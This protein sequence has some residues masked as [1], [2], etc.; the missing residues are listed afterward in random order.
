MARA[1]SV[2][3][4]FSDVFRYRNAVRRFLADPLPTTLEG[5][6]HKDRRAHRDHSEEGTLAAL[7]YHHLYIL[8]ARLG[9]SRCRLRLARAGRPDRLILTGRWGD[10]DVSL[11]Y[12]AE[13]VTPRHFLGTLDLNQPDNDALLEMLATVVVNRSAPKANAG[14][15]VWAERKLVELIDSL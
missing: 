3:I 1:A 11:E 10:V 4:Y 5:C 6:W 2:E 13:A 15:S 14:V 12:R 8:A 9:R 7:A